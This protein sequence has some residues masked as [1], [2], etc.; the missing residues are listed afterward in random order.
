MVGDAREQEAMSGDSSTSLIQS[1]GVKQ[2][3]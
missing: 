1:E 3:L 2:R